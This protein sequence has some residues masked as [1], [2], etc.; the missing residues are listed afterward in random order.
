MFQVTLARFRS[1]SFK[2]SLLL[3]LF[4]S[5]GS[6]T[7]MGSMASAARFDLW[8]ASASAG[9]YILHNNNTNEYVETIDCRVAFR[10]V[11]DQTYPGGIRLYD[12]SRGLYVYLD[13][14]YMRLWPRG[15]TSWTIHKTGSFDER[16]MFEHE[17]ASGAVTG[18]IWKKDACAWQEFIGGT[19]TPDF[20]FYEYRLTYGTVVL[21]DP[22]RNMYVMLGEESM[23]LHQGNPPSGTEWNF[24]KKGHWS[25]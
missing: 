6:A 5:A 1:S 4:L 21:R 12:A 18:A 2:K 8:R 9:N 19:A 23:Y 16:Y 3:A 22:S 14:N 20:S 10:F 25:P 17:D 15:A 11:L 13:V 7:L 24:F